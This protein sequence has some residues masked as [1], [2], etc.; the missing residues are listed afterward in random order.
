MDATIPASHNKAK[1]VSRW[2]RSVSLRTWTRGG[3]GKD[4]IRLSPLSFDA[5]NIEIELF[6]G[7]EAKIDWGMPAS[8]DSFQFLISRS[9]TF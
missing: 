1:I 6:H 7:G 8:C 2:F 4:R 3:L 9:W 5:L